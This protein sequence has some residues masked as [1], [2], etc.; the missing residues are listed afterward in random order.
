VGDE[1]IISAIRRKAGLGRRPPDVLPNTPQKALRR[2]VEKASQDHLGLRI[3]VEDYEEKRLARSKLADLVP[4]H[5][6]ISLLRT[7]EDHYG[8]CLMCAASV[9]A[10]VEQQTTG[11]VLDIA[12]QARAP[13]ATDGIICGVLIDYI[14]RNFEEESD[15]LPQPPADPGFR[16]MAC[17]EEARSI[18]LAFEDRTYSVYEL[19]LQIGD[20]GRAGRL[21]FVFPQISKAHAASGDEVEWEERFYAQIMESEAQMDTVL[22]REHVSLGEALAFKVGDL[23]ALPPDAL[24]HIDLCAGG[25]VFAS[26]KLGQLDGARAVR[27]GAS[28]PS[29]GFNAR[30]A[31][32][33]MV[34]APLSLD[35]LTA[36]MGDLAMPAP[37]DMAGMGGMTA[38]QTGDQTE[39]NPPDELDLAPLTLPVPTPLEELP[40]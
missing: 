15:A 24:Y 7:D 37:L 12:P 1:E 27:L 9:A 31:S 32:P 30:A 18:A 17:L 6:L 2:A 8:L 22:A 5:G 21:I 13:T 10:V 14:L 39:E 3:S 36:G 29:E 16:Y 20:V 40:E 11:R 4:E 19:T 34:P 28:A 38:D 25:R 23:I 26:G 33:G 35:P